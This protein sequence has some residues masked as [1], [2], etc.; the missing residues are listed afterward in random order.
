M[1]KSN[2]AQGQMV[3]NYNPQIMDKPRVWVKVDDTQEEPS[4]FIDNNVLVQFAINKHRKPQADEKWL[5]TDEFYGK[6]VR[7]G[8]FVPIDDLNQAERITEELGWPAYY[9]DLGF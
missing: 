2:I 8:L 5:I 4:L 9:V 7:Q 6:M 3:L 1:A